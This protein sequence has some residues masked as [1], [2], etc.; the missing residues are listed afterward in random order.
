ML[1]RSILVPAAL[2]SSHVDAFVMPGVT[3]RPFVD[4]HERGSGGFAMGATACTLNKD[5][6]LVC[7]PGGGP[8]APKGLRIVGDADY[9]EIKSADNLIIDFYAPLCGPCRLAEPALKCFDASTRDVTVVKTQLNDNPK[10]HAWVRAHGL[11]VEFLPT[12]VLVKAGRPVRTTYGTDNILNSVS[13]RAFALG[14]LSEEEAVA[15]TQRCTAEALL[16]G[17]RKRILLT[18]F[19]AFDS[20]NTGHVAHRDFELAIMGLN[21]P[22]L[23]PDVVRITRQCADGANGIIDYVRFTN[24]L[25]A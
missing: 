15:A 6:R 9:D 5:G 22:P 11:K 18:A 20:G 8:A 24:Q 17:S 12:L 4:V 16:N 13:L 1:T 23:P 3:P 25:L 19:K 2:L 21:L 7:R 14:E 10:I